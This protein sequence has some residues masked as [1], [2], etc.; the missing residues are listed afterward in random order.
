MGRDPFDSSGV[1]WRCPLKHS[2]VAAL[3]SEVYIKSDTWDGSDIAVTDTLFG[4]GRNLL[5]PSPL[6]IISKRIYSLL[7]MKELKGLSYEVAHLA[8]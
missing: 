6:I 3:L 7:K 1:E 5:R 4:E 8:C 2:I